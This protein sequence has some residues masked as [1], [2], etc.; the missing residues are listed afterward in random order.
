MNQI[1]TDAT[2]MMVPALLMKDHPRSHMLPSMVPKVGIWYAGS[3]MTKGAGLPEKALSFFRMMPESSTDAIPM[4]Y[5]LGAT[6][7]APPKTAPAIR[8]MIG[9]FAP[10]G[11]KVVVMTVICLSFSFSMVLEAMT[12]GTPQPV[13]I[14]MGHEAL[15]RKTEAAEHTVEDECDSGH[16]PAAFQEG[17]Q[18]E[19]DQHLGYETQYRTDTRNH[20]VYHAGLHLVIDIRRGHRIAD[21]DG[22]AGNPDAVIGRIGLF[23]FQGSGEVGR[24][25]LDR[26]VLP[27]LIIIGIILAD[28]PGILR[29]GHRSRKPCRVFRIDF[30]SRLFGGLHI[31]ADHGIGIFVFAGSLFPSLTT[32]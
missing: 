30:D 14:S 26:F 6:H 32:A 9:N 16:V 29:P 13:A 23:H 2:R 24:T 18:E 11:M 15:A 31:G 5:T 20:A 3:S 21:H 19:Q 12:P 25:H 22:N 17:E 10:Q 8:A 7:Q 4:K 1:R 28:N 27:R